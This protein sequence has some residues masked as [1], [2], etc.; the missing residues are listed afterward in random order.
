MLSFHILRL[1]F[2]HSV[3]WALNLLLFTSSVIYV[4]RGGGGSLAL[5]GQYSRSRIWQRHNNF[6]AWLTINLYRKHLTFAR[7]QS[8]SG[9]VNLIEFE[10]SRLV[11]AV[12]IPNT[13][14]RLP[15]F[16]V[17]VCNEFFFFDF[18]HGRMWDAILVF[19]LR[20]RQRLLET[21]VD[22]RKCS[23]DSKS[24]ANLCTAVLRIF[25]FPPVES[26]NCWTL[27]DAIPD[28]RRPQPVQFLCR[29]R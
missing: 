15:R 20:R 29:R 8:L 12:C 23:S 6:L 17:V 10:M 9:H 24:M 21:I 5:I 3:L 4:V 14:T 16:I 7:T 18:P 13:R 27:C 2:C 26:V 22:C 25:S 11:V 19:Y 1:R 28:W